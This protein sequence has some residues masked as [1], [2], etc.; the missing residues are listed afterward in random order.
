MEGS[1]QSAE[2][3]G[4]MKGLTVQP[5]TQAVANVTGWKRKSITRIDP[6]LGSGKRVGHWF[7]FLSLG[8]SG[9]GRFTSPSPSCS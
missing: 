1:F 4:R 6:S 3:K 5:H 8:R 7:L 9:V 2:G